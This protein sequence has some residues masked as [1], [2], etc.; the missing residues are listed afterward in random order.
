[1]FVNCSKLTNLDVNH[2]DTSKVTD[3]ASM[4]SGMQS[5]TTL[6][7]RGF[8]TAS[9]TNM[10]SMFDSMTNLVQVDLSSFNTQNVTS[11]HSTFRS[12][13]KLTTIYVGNG[14]TTANVTTS[15]Q[16]FYYA[17]KLPNYNASYVDVSKAYVGSGGYLTYKA[18]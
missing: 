10:N 16:M 8:N 15:S 9:L 12:C 3:M 11:M 7:L 13:E 17:V 4:F 1:M 2:F 5:I 14:W 6:D 18:S